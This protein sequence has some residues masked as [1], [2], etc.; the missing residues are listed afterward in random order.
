M[1]IGS[2]TACSKKKDTSSINVDTSTKYDVE[3]SSEMIS[4]NYTMVSGLYKAEPYSGEAIEIAAN[5]AYQ[6]GEGS[7]LTSETNGYKNDAVS[8]EIGDSATFKINVPETALYYLSF[9]YYDNSDSV[10]PIEAKLTLNGEVPFYEARRLVFESTWVDDKEVSLDRFGN[11]IVAVPDK[12]RQWENKYLM[13]ASYRWST[14]LA[15]ELKA[16]E[17]EITLSLAEGSVLFGNIYLNPEKVVPEYAGS[18]KAEGDELIT[19]QAE[20]ITY[21]NSSS[22]RATC[23]YDID[24]EPYNST[25]KVLNVID[26]TSFT[27]AGQTVAYEFEVEK[28]GYYNLAMN[29]MQGDKAD[30]PVF[31][32]VKVDGELPNTEFAAYSFPYETSYTNRVLKDNDKNKLSVYLEEGKH[33]VS[34]TIN[35]D[36]IRHVLEAVDRIMNEINDMTLEITK[37]AGTN[38]DKYRD[39]EILKYIP[40]A[41]DRL[42]NWADQLDSLQNSVKKYNKGV[43]NIAA[44]SPI[45]VASSQLRSLAEDPE[46]LPYRISELSQSVSS[47]NQFL[48]NL[49]DKLNANDIA[50]DR[51]YVYQDGASLP[52]KSNFLYKGYKSVERFFTSFSQQAYST[53]NINEDHIQVWVNRSRQYVEIMQKMIDESFTPQTGIK[54]DLSIMP[55]QNKLVLANA[56]GD[57]PDIATS[58]NYAIPF[59]LGVRGAIKD[60]TEF[61]DFKDVATRYQDGL[62]VPATIGNGI[63]ALPETMNF[64]VLYYRTDILD[65]LG[66]KVPN[67]IE[68]VKDMLPELQMRGYNFYYPTAGMIALKTFHGTT[69][70]LFQ[71]SATLYNEDA[72]SA[73]NSEEAIKGFT[74]LTELF[75]IYNLPKDIP[76]FYQHFRNGDLPIGIAE[77]NM[78]NLLTNAAPEIANSWDISVVP[79]VET[80]T[81]EV[82]RYTSAGAE[83]TVMFKS[84]SEREAQAWE[85]M[86]W[87]SSKDVQVEFG[88]T[89]Q[90]TYGDEFIWN[91]ANT[92]AF[93]EL[94]WKTEDKKVILEQ[95]NWTLEGPRMLGSYMVEREISNA[96]NSIVV[97]GKNLRTTIDGA[98]KRIDR[99]TKRKLEEFGYID[100]EGN[101]LEQYKVPDIDTVKRILGKEE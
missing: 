8:M 1:V 97:D 48:A 82:L 13:D 25:N 32:D 42:N 79:G 53:S 75:T 16:G 84:N 7:E 68:D 6:G 73:I 58:I 60:L 5:D 51:I 33:T 4:H 39:F 90:V 61:S 28:A 57:A 50:I 76:N 89:L 69:P 95:S 23:E 65:K 22:I 17:N 52:S 34:F 2:F 64:W 9:D 41:G 14:P 101:V 27:D 98:V 62:H 96:Y 36:N 100:S 74:D 63:Y 93:A 38:K 70:L 26:S 30:F 44:F 49:I 88:Q 18:E 46:D 37:V 91:T 80:E 78:Y 56:S 35:I 10:L 40:D 21:R 54:V 81:G 71:N 67:T 86:K 45:S 66:L 99:E 85:F 77:Y 47:V 20:D 83:S 87:W 19:I 3:Y 31:L 15:L 24:L 59:E 11:E 12:L 92:E 55:D 43:D 29:Y 94:P 72:T